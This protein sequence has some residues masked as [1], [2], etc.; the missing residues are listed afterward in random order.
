MP[1]FAIIIIVLA[2]AAVV[3]LIQRTSAASPSEPDDVN[4]DD[5]IRATTE[6]HTISRRLDVAWTRT[7]LNRDSHRLRRDLSREMRRIDRL[8]APERGRD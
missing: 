2:L 6:L 4:P 1:A 5:V 3:L 8:E 7:E